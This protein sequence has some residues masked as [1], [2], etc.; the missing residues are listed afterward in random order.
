[1]KEAQ[2]WLFEA[3]LDVL[4]RCLMEDWETSCWELNARGRL[5]HPFA[6]HSGDL[7]QLRKRVGVQ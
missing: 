4:L 6:R 1:M 2:P 7:E 3:I 5:L